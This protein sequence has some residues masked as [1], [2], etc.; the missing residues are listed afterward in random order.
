[1]KE[2]GTRIR[3]AL[4]IALGAAGLAGANALSTGALPESSRE[5]SGIAL[6]VLGAALLALGLCGLL[7]PRAQLLWSRD[8]RVATQALRLM[9]LLG[10]VAVSGFGLWFG[11]SEFRDLRALQSD[12][13]MTQAQIATIETVGVNS[14]TRR[15]A[16]AFRA[17][18]TAILQ[19]AD[20][21]RD[22]VKRLRM[23]TPL[24][25]T[26]LPT[27]PHTYRLGTV[28]GARV[29]RR[30]AILAL[31]VVRGFAWFGIPFFYLE[32]Q[33]RRLLRDRKAVAPPSGPLPVG[34]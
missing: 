1:M 16:Y 17:G 30:G 2:P 15:V 31:F 8:L 18:G 3:Q 32:T 9:L 26:Y 20:L 11:V 4:L 10:L 5:L 13:R 23:G 21:T 33:R 19:Q 7:L 29:L 27:Q 28:D 24:T 34:G 14:P 6:E 22:E 25:V 12:G